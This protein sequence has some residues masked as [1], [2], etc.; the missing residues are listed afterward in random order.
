MISIGWIAYLVS[1]L[2]NFA[3]GMMLPS[4]TQD[5]GFGIEV[6]GY[7]S[8]IGWIFK[9]ICII[10]IALVV[11]KVKPKYVLIGSYLCTGI[12]LIM[13]GAATTVPVLL[14]GR[15]LMSIGNAGFLSP[16]V[17]IKIAYVPKEKIVQVNGLENCVG[18]IGQAMGTAA[19]ASLLAIMSG[20]RN[21]MYVLGGIL[22]VLAVLM[23]VIYKEKEGHEFQKSDVKFLEPLKEALKI[24]EVWLLAIAWPGTSLVWIAFY[25]FWPTFAMETYGMTLAQT[26]FVLGLFPIFSGIASFVAP[27]I[28]NWL[29]YDRHMMWPWGFILPV[30]YFGMLQTDNMVILCI[31]SIIAG[32]GA[33]AWVPTAFSV[34][35]KL[36]NV[37]PR[38]VTLGTSCILTMVSVGSTLGGSLAGILGQSMGLYKAMAICCLS[39]ILFGILTLFLPERGRKYQE[40][41]EKEN[42][43]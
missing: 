36:P 9:A 6:S 29:G 25:T 33:Y 5:I 42:A 1:N 14:V 32:F 17:P 37:K 43:K 16:L 38:V 13:Q 8:S 21:V 26:G 4:M 3:L 27:T 2:I 24:K 30:A 12:S 23:A 7:L 41:M 22:I 20:W 31:C 18:P 34:L 40:R 28:A 15:A 19:I 10:P 39:P 11:S 35:Y